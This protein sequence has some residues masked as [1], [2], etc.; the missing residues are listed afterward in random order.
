MKGQ[1]GGVLETVWEAISL[2]QARDDGWSRMVA[3]IQ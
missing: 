3:G 2:I 1:D